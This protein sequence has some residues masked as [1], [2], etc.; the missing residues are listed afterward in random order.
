MSIAAE[1]ALLGA[2]M[3]EPRTLARARAIVTDASDF[4]RSDHRTIWTEILALDAAGA[5]IDVVTVSERLQALGRLDD[6]GGQSYLGL[7]A[8]ETASAANVEAYANA[9]VKDAA[10]R[11]ID[12]EL[13]SSLARV[14]HEEPA[15]LV[16]ELVDR[17]SKA[18]KAARRSHDMI[19][20]IDLGFGYFANSGGK[21]DLLPTG[22]QP[23]DDEI[24]GLEAGRLYVVAARTGM[25]KSAL[26]I[27]IAH[28]LISQSFP[29][30]F[31]SLEMTCRE[32]IHRLFAHRYG[33]NLTAL[34]RRHGAIASELDDAYQRDPMSPLAFYVDDETVDLPALLARAHEWHHEHRIRAL[35][36]DYIGLIQVPGKAPRHEKIGEASRAFKQLAKRLS[37]PVV[38]AAQFN[39]DAEKDDRKPRLSDLRDSG[40]IEQDADVVIAV[41]PLSEP[42]EKGRR[43]V[44]IGLLKNRSGGTGRITDSITFEGRTQRFVLTST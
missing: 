16:A 3:L 10:R 23:L 1:K 4:A 15:T 14:H 20:L 25:G 18:P 33:L 13:E 5:P 40:S 28:H 32:I 44:T 27:S 38:V 21:A 19:D 36:I 7:L 22:L 24:G 35:F 2:V 39:R 8:T 42:D 11:F 30:G 6:I 17:L 37:I 12:R 34:T 9:V 29:I 26:A 43:P 41:S 31:C